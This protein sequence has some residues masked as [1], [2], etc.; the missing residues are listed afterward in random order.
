M[1]TQRLTVTVPARLYQR[2]RTKLP[3]RGVS[4]FVAKAVENEL[5]QLENASQDP[6][7]D[8]LK[9]RGRMP[10]FTTKQILRAIDKGRQ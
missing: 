6:V 7:E 2:I 1:S 3:R 9:L 4:Q 10:K 8:W 5:F